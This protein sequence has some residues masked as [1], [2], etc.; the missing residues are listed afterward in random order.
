MKKTAAESGGF[1]VS[2]RPCSIVQRLIV[3]DVYTAIAIDVRYDAEILGIV[4]EVSGDL[5][6]RKVF[7]QTLHILNIYHRG[8]RR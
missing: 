4:L 5:I 7:V 8:C 3:E 2:L 1:R 6:R